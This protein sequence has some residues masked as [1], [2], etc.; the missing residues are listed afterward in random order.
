MTLVANYRDDLG[1]LFGAYPMIVGRTPLQNSLFDFLPTQLQSEYQDFSNFRGCRNNALQ[2]RKL[3]LTF[4][5]NFTVDVELPITP[6][7]QQVR[8][9]KEN[10]GAVI[11]ETIG[12]RI[13]YTKL[14]WL[15][16]VTTT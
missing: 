3:R 5:E 10:A 1:N 7:I 8:Q 9:I 11:I 16:G 2:P 6:T 12:E 14:K 13:K 4:D 15:V